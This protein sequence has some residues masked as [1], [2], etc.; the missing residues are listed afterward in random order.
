MIRT[1]AR[2]GLN[3][4]RRLKNGLVNGI[5]PPVVVLIY[6]RV[7]TLAS[8]PQLLAVTPENFRDQMRYLRDTFPVLRFEAAWR[9]VR[10]PSVVVTFDDGYAD[11]FLEAL[12]ILEEFGIPA[13]FFVTSGA[14]GSDQEFWW[15]ELE[16][17]ILG[18]EPKP[19][20]CR[21][22]T[23]AQPREWET[24]SRAGRDIFYQ[25]LHPLVRVLKPLERAAWLGQLREW[26]GCGR[27]GR[28]SHRV[29]SLEELN[30]LAQSALVTLGAHGVTHTRLSSL[31]PGEQR[32]EIV[33]SQK[34]LEEL[35]GQAVRVFSFP[36]GGSDDYDGTTLELCREAGFTRVAANIPGQAHRW[37]ERLQ[38][39]RHLVRNWSLDE[40]KRNLKGFIL[41]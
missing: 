36:F 41:P 3:R 15:D 6:H 5:D 30:G 28:H 16:R 19:E 27:T 35:C 25:E 26:S 23:P 12:P 31:S 18:P 40:F 22:G 21:L 9:P 37:S 1:L 11:N 20:R 39:P 2:G 33:Q 17:L 8:D 10:R 7:T 34:R 24:A 38:V 32:E 29:L 14:L 4:L 13:T